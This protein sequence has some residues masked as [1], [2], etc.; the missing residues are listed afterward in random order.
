MANLKRIILQVTVA[1]LEDPVT[2]DCAFGGM[3][4]AIVDAD[5]L[6]L[7]IKASEGRAISKLGEEI[8]ASLWE[9]LILVFNIAI[10]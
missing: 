7:D 4:Y 3:W 2:V 1:G 5:S 8:K 9:T 6:G 10:S